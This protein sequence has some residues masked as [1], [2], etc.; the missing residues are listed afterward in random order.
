MKDFRTRKKRKQPFYYSWFFLV[1]LVLVLGLFVKSAYASFV[2]KQA[3]DIEKHKYE[4][5]LNELIDKK[6]YLESKIQHL[7]TNRGKEEALRSRFNVTKE[8]ETI[9]KIIEK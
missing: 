1:V 4:Q 9:I 6:E 5:K 7:K 3:A 8:G 2:K